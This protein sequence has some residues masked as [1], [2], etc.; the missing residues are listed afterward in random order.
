MSREEPMLRAYG[1][2]NRDM[3]DRSISGSGKYSYSISG[4][5]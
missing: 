4:E 5:E 1:P 3:V 2:W